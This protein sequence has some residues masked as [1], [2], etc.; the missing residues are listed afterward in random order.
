MAGGSLICDA[1]RAASEP[2][3][4]LYLGGMYENTAQR[5]SRAVRDVPDFPKPGVVFKDLSGVWADPDLCRDVVQCVADEARGWQVEAVAGIE[6]RGFLI[7]L[8]V[9][10]ALGVPFVLIRKQGK[11]PGAVH[12]KAYSL[13]YGE[14]VIEVQQG[15]FQ[16]GQRVLVH[17]DVLATGGTAAACGELVRQAGAEVVGWSFLVELTFLLGRNRLASGAEF[18]RP[19]LKV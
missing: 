13:E 5:F 17:D 10:M 6:S 18:A 2:P 4:A 3:F 12:Q 14:A 7:G 11:L 16:P 19:L 9:A 1:A 15:A 8:P